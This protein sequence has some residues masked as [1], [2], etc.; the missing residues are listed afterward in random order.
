MPRVVSY[1]LIVL[2]GIVAIYAQ[3]GEL[4]N[5]MVLIAGIVILMVGIYSISRNIPSKNQDDEDD[6]NP[7]NVKL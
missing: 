2:G 5:Q 4:Q 1:I 7:P 6:Y 3:A